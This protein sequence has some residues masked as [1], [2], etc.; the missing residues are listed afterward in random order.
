MSRIL[1]DTNV[2][3]DLVVQDNEWRT[4]SAQAVTEAARHSRLVINQIILAE[5]SIGFERSEDVDALIDEAGI[6]REDLPWEAAFLAG[7]AYVLY[8]R[9]N[10]QKRSPLPDFFIGAHAA[11]R[12]YTLLT[13]DARL[14]RTYFPGVP[15]IT[16]P[17]A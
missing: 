4:W 15:L 14:Q 3:L 6:E 5:V 9:R 17:V 16:P 7:K 1:I 8:R 11:T 13:R 2:I 10:G 12:G